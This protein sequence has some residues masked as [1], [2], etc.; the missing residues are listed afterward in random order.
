MDYTYCSI[1]VEIGQHRP[2]Y[3]QVWILFLTWLCKRD[4]FMS[5]CIQTNTAERLREKNM[6]DVPEKQIKRLRA[7]IQEAETNL[8][9]ANELLISLVG[10]DE[11]ITPVVKDDT[12]GKIIEGVFDGQNMAGSDGKT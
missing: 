5:K 9:A 11:K 12:L 1:L 3:P 8:A 10:D 2:S 4:S 6:A 7:L